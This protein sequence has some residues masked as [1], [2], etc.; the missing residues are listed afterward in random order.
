M[1]HEEPDTKICPWCGEEIK[2]KAII[3]R[4]CF[5]DV[6]DKGIESARKFAESNSRSSVTSRSQETKTSHSFISPPESSVKRLQKFIPKTLLEGIISGAEDLAEG[7]RRP[8]A[9]L[10]SDLAGFTSLTEELGAEWMSD[11]LDEIYD[12]TREIINSYGGV[13]DKFIGDAVMAIFGAPRAHGDDPERAIRAA[14]DIRE[15]VLQIGKE[16]EY[17]LDTHSGIA[18]GEV[19]LKSR[20]TGHGN[21]DFRTIG[22]AVNLASRLEGKAPTGRIYVD[23]RIY[24]QTRTVFDWQH[25]EPLMVKGKKEAVK[26][27]C[28]LTVKKEFSKVALGERFELVPLV[29]RETELDFL[30]SALEKTMQGTGSVISIR[31]DAGIGKS[32]LVY[33]FYQLVRNRE[34]NWYT[35]RCLSFGTHVPFLSFLS[36][37]RSILGLPREGGPDINEKLIQNRIRSI[38]ENETDEDSGDAN[39]LLEEKEIINALALLFSLQISD[40]TLFELSP[41]QRRNAIFR[42]INNLVNRLAGQRPTILIFEDFHWSDEDSLSLLN[43]LIENLVHKPVMFVVLTRYFPDIVLNQSEKYHE[44][45]IKELSSEHSKSLLS[46]IL[47]FKNVPASLTEEI[48]EKAGGNPFYIEEVILNLADQ[49]C[50]EKSGDGYDL[51]CPVE[52]IAIPDSVENVVLARLDILESNIKRVLQ[53][54]S[55]IGLEFRY[56]VLAHISE[57]QKNLQNHLSSLESGEYIFKEST[58][59]ELIYMF[60]NLVLRDVTYSTLLEKR[61]RHF[62]ALIA[63]ILEELKGERS[64]ENAELIAHH[65]ELGAVYD[66]AVEYCE[67]AAKKCESLYSQ[68]AAADFWQKVVEYVEKTSF[69]PTSIQQIRLRANLAFGEICRRLGRPECGIKAFTSAIKDSGDLDDAKSRV[70]A[71]RGLGEAYRQAGEI[72]KAE[73]RVKESLDLALSLNDPGLLASC[74]NYL[75]NL[76]RMKGDFSGAGESFRK[77][78]EYARGSGDRLRLYQAMNHLGIVEMYGGNPDLAGDYFRKALDLAVEL[79]KKNEQVQ[80]ELNLAINYLRSGNVLKSERIL[81][82]ALERAEKL[83]FELGAQLAMLALSD[84]KLKTG[85][86]SESLQITESLL[87]RM[88]KA[89]FSDVRAMTL[90]NFARGC[91][92]TGR[93]KEAASLVEKALDAGRADENYAVIIDAVAVK[94]ELLLSQGDIREALEQAQY[95]LS[96]VEKHQEREFEPRVLCLLAECLYKKGSVEECSKTSGKAAEIA[97]KAGIPRDHA[98]A[99]FLKSR[100]LVN[101]EPGRADSL[102]KQAYELARKSG[103]RY[104]LNRI[105]ITDKDASI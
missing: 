100:C 2:R 46:R 63:K 33:E 75:G 61:K 44:I 64:E 16:R 13:V 31:G 97:D 67:M 25:I 23:H 34:I 26:V 39:S 6:T 95:L 101:K 58:S 80:I 73:Q 55:V 90:S 4:F 45:V 84:L 65:Y 70:C 42:A 66:K 74:Y 82:S 104:L 24:L 27:H 36:L 53:C 77:V 11:L 71:L 50:L 54:A 15:Q 20:S 10:F 83:E 93:I 72:D 12:G 29:G 89:H 9:I 32:R 92:G 14:L 41:K 43:H 98:Y 81:Y 8:I 48:L 59:P 99:L 91:L 49:N 17:P 86:F 76:Q 3:C 94:V 105:M 18:Y 57:L 22:D 5:N 78:L 28:P 37:F 52:S 85:D 7:E 103:D 87:M 38:Y 79:G 102:K 88:D 19:V 96:L 69:E 62:H 35:G 68:R 56:K 30:N 40:N 21:L 51:V 47:D 60:R 1:P